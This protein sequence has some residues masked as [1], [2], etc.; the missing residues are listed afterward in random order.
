VQPHGGIGIVQEFTDGRTL[1]GGAGLEE[2]DGGG[3]P[4]GGQLVAEGGDEGGVGRAVADGEHGQGVAEL[5]GDGVVV[6]EGGE[7][8]QHLDGAGGPAGGQHAQGGRHDR[9]VVLQLDEADAL[10]GP[11]G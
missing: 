8:E 2:G 10:L 11:A 1:L 7:G 3:G 4:A 9:G 5:V 6:G